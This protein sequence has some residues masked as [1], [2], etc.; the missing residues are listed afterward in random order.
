MRFGSPIL[1]N[2]KGRYI[3]MQSL[4]L[5]DLAKLCLYE[6]QDMRANLNRQKSDDSK[7]QKVNKNKNAVNKQTKG[8]EADASYLNRDLFTIENP[9]TS[10]AAL[11]F[12]AQLSN[13]KLFEI[14]QRVSLR[15]SAK[16]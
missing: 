1:K 9:P 8:G 15:R 14:H 12:R 7:R 11:Y 5:K 6:S 4:R 10:S 3:P 2:K 16:H 13:F